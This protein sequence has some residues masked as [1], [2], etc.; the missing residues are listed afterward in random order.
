MEFSFS[1]SLS[2]EY[3]VLISCRTDVGIK[4]VTDHLNR[5]LVRKRCCGKN[6]NNE[7]FYEAPHSPP[8]PLHV[9]SMLT[10]YAAPSETQEE[11]RNM[12]AGES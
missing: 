5:K 2:N 12:Q 3:S 7:L 10:S 1:I 8:P 4:R 11:G 9:W 6:I